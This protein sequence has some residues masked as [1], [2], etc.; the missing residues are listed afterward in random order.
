MK[1]ASYREAIQWVADNDGSGDAER[2]DLEEVSYLVSSLLV[3]DLFG[4]DPERVGRDVIRKRK[5]LDK[6]GNSHE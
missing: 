1:R 5:Q 3:A 6:K 2:L 4:V